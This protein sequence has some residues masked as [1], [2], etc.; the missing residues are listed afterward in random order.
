MPPPNKWY[1][2]QLKIERAASESDAHSPDESL[3]QRLDLERQKFDENVQVLP[4]K[5]VDAFNRCLDLLQESAPSLAKRTRQARSRRLR[6]RTILANIFSKVGPEVFLLCASAQA[7]STLTE[8]P[9]DNLITQLQSWW[10][11]VSHPRG[12]TETANQICETNSIRTLV[13]EYSRFLD[14]T[15]MQSPPRPQ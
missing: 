9:P 3:I 6:G 15:G 10:A 11:G 14:D 13:A 1:T 2:E 8:K 12:L 7:I 4:Q 5:Q